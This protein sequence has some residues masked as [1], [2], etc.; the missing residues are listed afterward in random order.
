A[1]HMPKIEETISDQKV[2]S[3]TFRFVTPVETE[4]LKIPN[5]CNVCHSDKSTEWAKTALE[6][7]AD[8]SPWRM[9]K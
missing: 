5:A 8:R 3:H 6:S 4:T 2:R 9:T 1:C 7:W